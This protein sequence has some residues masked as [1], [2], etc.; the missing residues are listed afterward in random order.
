MGCDV[1]AASTA[2]LWRRVRKEAT[3]AADELERR[4]PGLVATNV[5]A[6][7]C[8]E[9]ATGLDPFCY[10]H[11]ID[12]LKEAAAEIERLHELMK[13]ERERA[14]RT[15]VRSIVQQRDISRFREQLSFAD[16]ELLTRLEGAIELLDSSFLGIDRVRGF[17]ARV[18]DLAWRFS[19]AIGPATTK[20]KE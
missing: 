1:S 11:L 3:E 8:I 10:R 12:T 15:A 19:V 2:E 16:V 4:L 5:V 17:R 14:D 18:A 7:R 20:D 13:Y 9:K 6:Q